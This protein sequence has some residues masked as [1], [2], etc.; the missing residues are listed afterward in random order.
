MRMRALGAQAMCEMLSIV[1]KKLEEVTKDKKRLEGYFV[2]LEKWAKSKARAC[3]AQCHA[4]RRGCCTTTRSS[5]ACP[6]LCT[7]KVAP[8]PGRC[9]D[10]CHP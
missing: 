5:P 1:G 7:V 3:I 6:L 2:I 8:A 10:C 9:S 4:H